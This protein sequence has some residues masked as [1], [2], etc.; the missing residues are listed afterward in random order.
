M[1]SGLGDQGIYKSLLLM[2]KAT[3]PW[4]LGFMKLTLLAILFFGSSKSSDADFFDI[5]DQMTAEYLTAE[6]RKNDFGRS[7]GSSAA[8]TSPPKNN[9]YLEAQSVDSSGMVIPPLYHQ[10]YRASTHW[11]GNSSALRSQFLKSLR[12]SDERQRGTVMSPPRNNKYL[13][14]S[15]QIIKGKMVRLSRVHLKH[16]KPLQKPQCF[17][18]KAKKKKKFTNS[19]NHDGYESN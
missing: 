17:A 1:R 10:Y 19:H 3:L 4:L 16:P 11:R 5:V 7:G 14:A 2:R 15:M 8:V 9:K 12:L 18:S 6:K 13:E